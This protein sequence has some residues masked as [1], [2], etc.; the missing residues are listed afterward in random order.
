[1]E[2]SN[3]EVRF[4]SILAFIRYPIDLGQVLR[5]FRWIEYDQRAVCTDQEVRYGNFEASGEDEWFKEEIRNVNNLMIV[6]NKKRD[7]KSV[8]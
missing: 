8:V 1:M 6:L 7:R 3:I 4:L 5:E 2:K